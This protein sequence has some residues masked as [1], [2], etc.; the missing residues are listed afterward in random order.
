MPRFNS[1][2]LADAFADLT[3]Y[4]LEAK[5][6]GALSA[7][8]GKVWTYAEPLAAWY[9]TSKGPV[10]WVN[11]KWYSTTSSKHRTFVGGALRRHGHATVDF[12]APSS[13]SGTQF[14]RGR[15]RFPTLAEVETYLRQIAADNLAGKDDPGATY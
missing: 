5:S 3:Y 13:G 14:T 9:N 4:P 8:D 1:R 6:G 15:D 12:D 11:T 2:S 7:S 10:A